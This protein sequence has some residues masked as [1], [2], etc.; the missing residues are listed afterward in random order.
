MTGAGAAAAAEGA[1][2][3]EDAGEQRLSQQSD[4][5]ETRARAQ[6][7]AQAQTRAQ[8]QAQA[9]VREWERWIEAGW[10]VAAAAADVG[11]AVAVAVAV[12]QQQSQAAAVVGPS[13]SCDAH[14]LLGWQDVGAGQGPARR[15]AES[16]GRG[17]GDAVVNDRGRPGWSGALSQY[18]QPSRLCGGPSLLWQ[19]MRPWSPWRTAVLA[20]GTGHWVAVGPPASEPGARC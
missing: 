8:A 12:A 10:E 16:G 14:S 17:G 18:H 19:A 15:Y 4:S 6:A 9:W 20:L 3:A 13:A 5:A 7:Q 1:G 11:A 2:A